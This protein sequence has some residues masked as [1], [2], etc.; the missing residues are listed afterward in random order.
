MVTY[1]RGNDLSGTMQGAGG[2]GGLLARTDGSGSYYYH[3]DGNGNITAMVDT[4]GLTVAKYSY[5]PFGNILTMSGAMAA[6]NTYRF[7]SKD[8]NENS[9]LYYY[10]YRCYDPSLQRWLNRDPI[11][12]DGG[13]N[14]YE[15]VGNNPFYWY[16]PLGEDG[17][18]ACKALQQGLKWGARS[19]VIGGGPEDP[20]ADFVA[21]AILVG[22]TAY[23]G[24]EYIHT[25]MG[26][27]GQKGERNW[28]GSQSGTGN[29]YK[30]WRVD[31]KDPTKIRG[32]DQNGKDIVK[33]RPPDFPDPKP[34]PPKQNPPSQSSGGSGGSS[35]GKGGCN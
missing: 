22:F 20:V 17:Q 27:Q 5:D 18:A 19:E 9:G 10:G 35:P 7:S 8:W 1:T 2:I 13:I 24:Y 12:E 21:G 33:P 6:V 26:W 28:A 15:F 34:Q 32:K 29:P 14:L 30:G 3:A 16:D 11:Q 4:N 23:A 25:P 31:P